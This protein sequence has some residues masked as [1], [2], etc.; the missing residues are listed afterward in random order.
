MKADDIK[1][2]MQTTLYH[3]T[4]SVKFIDKLGHVGLFKC[5]G[6]LREAALLRSSYL[7]NDWKHF[8]RSCKQ[9]L[10]LRT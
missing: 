6:L 7:F 10:Q 4:D 9:K 3:A 1:T 8:S 5:E 2:E